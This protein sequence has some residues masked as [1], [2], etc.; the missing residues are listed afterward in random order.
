MYRFKWLTEKNMAILM[1]W[2][3][4]PNNLFQ[5]KI[6]ESITNFNKYKCD[7]WSIVK[8]NQSDIIGNKN[9]YCYCSIEE[10]IIND[11]NTEDLASIM[12]IQSIKHGYLIYSI[13]EHMVFY[14]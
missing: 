10:L 8:Y 6:Y 7:L 1:K 12:Q 2:L 9:V 4:K 3:W 14:K 13:C 5:Y 11:N